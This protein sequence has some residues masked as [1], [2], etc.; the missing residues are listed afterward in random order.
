[1]REESIQGRGVGENAG[2]AHIGKQKF[3]EVYL[4]LRKEGVPGY[5]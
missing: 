2:N 5:S 1:M 4:T 3:G